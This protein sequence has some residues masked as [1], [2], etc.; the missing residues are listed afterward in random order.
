MKKEW[1]KPTLFEH[2]DIVRLTQDTPVKELGLPTDGHYL[3]GYGYLT[4][5]S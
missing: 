1:T 2:G 5:A 3:K 4:D